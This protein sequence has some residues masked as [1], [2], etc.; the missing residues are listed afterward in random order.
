MKSKQ[1]AAI[2]IIA[3]FLVLAALAVLWLGNAP[4]MPPTQTVTQ[5]IPDD[6]I[7]H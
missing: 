6:H 3:L 7:P 1:T 4:V 2:G 5:P